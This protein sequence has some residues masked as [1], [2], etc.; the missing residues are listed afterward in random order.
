MSKINSFALVIIIAISLA[1]CSDKSKDLVN[2]WRIDDVK[3]SKPR[4]PQMQAFV[5]S[6]IEYS[7][8]YVRTAYSSNGSFEQIVDSR[9]SKGSWDMSKDGKVIYSTDESGATTRFLIKE[10]TKDKFIYASLI[11]H[12]DTLTFYMVPFSAKDTVNRKPAPQMMQPR[13]Q[14]GPPQQEGGAPQ[15]GNA[16]AKSAQPEAPTKQK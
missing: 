12:Q 7:K 14:A 5:Q 16:P 13:S 1:S 9:S 2:T 8:G 4:P 11:G 15:Q 10:L 3:F 6:Q